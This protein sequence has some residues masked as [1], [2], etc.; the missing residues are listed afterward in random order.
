MKQKNSVDIGAGMRRR[1]CEVS[2]W[3]VCPASHSGGRTGGL[4]EQLL[5]KED[6]RHDYLR[7]QPKKR[8]TLP[9]YFSSKTSAL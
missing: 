6:P 9:V 8:G 1:F 2:R 4:M 3:L 7:A 5:T